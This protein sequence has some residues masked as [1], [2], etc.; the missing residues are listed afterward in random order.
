[1]EQ[2]EQV[3][4]EICKFM[5]HSPLESTYLGYMYTTC[6]FSPVIPYEGRLN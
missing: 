6:A 3:V 4:G 2:K 1:M 5:H